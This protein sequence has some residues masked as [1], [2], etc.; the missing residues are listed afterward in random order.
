MP[1]V[2]Q[3]FAGVQSVVIPDQSM[4]LQEIIRRFIKKESLPIAMEGVYDDTYDYDLEKLAKADITVREEVIAE[5][6]VKVATARDKLTADAK[7]K[8]DKE[9]ASKD[10][11]FNAAVLEASRA[12]ASVP[13][14]K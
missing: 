8:A 12:A 14:V 11:I 9:K 5:L 3:S 4:S 10:A 6:K 7:A 1:R 13:L 2:Q